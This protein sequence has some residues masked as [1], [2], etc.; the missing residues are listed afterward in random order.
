MFV[1]GLLALL[2]AL[3]KSLN[4]GETAVSTGNWSLDVWDPIVQALAIPEA[5]PVRFVKAWMDAESGGNPCAVGSITAKGPDG[6]PREMGL[7]QLYNPDDLKR[8]GVTGSELRAYCVPGTQRVSRKL[9][10][11]EMTT[12]VRAGIQL[13]KLSRSSAIAAIAKVGADF[14]RGPDFWRFVKLAH[15]LPALL[16]PGIVVVTKTLGRPPRDWAEF[17]KTA[18][19]IQWNS[20]DPAY[21]NIAKYQDAGRFPAILDNAE[22]T[23]GV[24]PPEGVA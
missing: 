18:E 14:G 23:G 1:L 22:K 6:N 13:I 15:A 12:Q 5:I 21:A 3:A 4:Q 7:F 11:A 17:R 19:N 9:T 24:V 8:V 10:P 2:A 20:L 16:N